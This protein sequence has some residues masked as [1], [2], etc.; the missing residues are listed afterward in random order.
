MS[1]P[2]AGEGGEFTAP[3]HRKA[4]DVPGVTVNWAGELGTSTI[5]N[6]HSSIVIH[7]LASPPD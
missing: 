6:Q 3:I 7:E 4:R 2:V 5:D 1:D